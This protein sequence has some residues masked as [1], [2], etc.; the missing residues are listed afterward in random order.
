M[1]KFLLGLIIGLP[2]PGG[3]SPV[4]L[5]RAVRALLDFLFV[6]QYPAHTS[7]TL[8]LLQDALRR[9]HAN[10]A[11]FVD[12]GIRLHFK[13]PKLHSLEHYMLSILLF[14][15]TDNYDTQYTERLHI[16]FAKDAYRATNRKDELPQMTAWLERREKILRHEIFIQ[17]RLSRR[18]ERESADTEDGSGTLTSSLP[19]L[20]AQ[21]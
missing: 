1:C 15:T 11:I 2:L 5:I 18:C 13:L 14:G 8:E 21:R 9:F 19:M 4:R 12:L 7:E 20:H 10:K 17:W 16:D 6:A 3:M